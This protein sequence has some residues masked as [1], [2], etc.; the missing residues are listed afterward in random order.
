MKKQSVIR[1]NGL[2]L[3][4][5]MRQR[6]EREAEMRVCALLHEK[7][8]D[9]EKKKGTFSYQ[10]TTKLAGNQYYQEAKDDKVLLVQLRK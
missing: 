7:L 2:V 8:R 1:R 9:H 6:G 3:E 10:G 5:I 4:H